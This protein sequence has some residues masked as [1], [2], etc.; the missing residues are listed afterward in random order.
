MDYFSWGHRFPVLEYVIYI[1]TLAFLDILIQLE[2][3]HWRNIIFVYNDSFILY[4]DSVV[5]QYSLGYIC[6]GNILRYFK[7][8]MGLGWNQYKVML[9]NFRL[10]EIKI[11]SELTWLWFWLHQLLVRCHPMQCS[12]FHKKLFILWIII[13]KWR[14]LCPG[15]I[16]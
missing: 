3:W 11:S 14:A 8:Q 2:N 4:I 12:D 5:H 13:V 16:L 1:M 7:R 10:N 6:L 15:C 9:T